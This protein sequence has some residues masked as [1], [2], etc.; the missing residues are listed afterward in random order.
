MNTMASRWSAR[1]AAVLLGLCLLTG[2][3]AQGAAADDSLYRALG[4]RAGLATLMDVFVERLAVDPRIGERFKKTDR[5]L[6]KEMLT[7]QLCVVSG[8][9]CKYKGADMKNA[10]ADMDITRAD[11]N[12]LV[13]VLQVS[14]EARA[15]P[16]ATQ[17]RLLAR[18]AP[19]H[20][21]IIGAAP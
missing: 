16:F 15:V 3:R 9:P 14:M 21:E 4:E 11:F 8:G 20:R 1:A 2:A 10:H 6:L 12:A 18:L 13:E 7:D 5:P 19:M 17:N